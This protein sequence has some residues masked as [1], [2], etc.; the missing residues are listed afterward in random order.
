MAMSVAAPGAAAAA[1][2]PSPIAT[3]NVG[4]PLGY[5]ETEM[6][7]CQNDTY[8]FYHNK[9]VYDACINAAYIVEHEDIT[10]ANIVEAGIAI[11]GLSLYVGELAV[12]TW[13][14]SSGSSIFCLLGY[15]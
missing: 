5:Y 3:P 9:Q 6:V 10:C 8:S 14:L 7:T 1:T 13:A 15:V 11:T 2:L 12:T 4:V